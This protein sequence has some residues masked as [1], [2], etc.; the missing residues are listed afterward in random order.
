[1]LQAT[2]CVEVDDDK[3]CRIVND[4]L[5]RWSVKIRCSENQGCGCCVNI[6]QVEAPQ[7]ALNELPTHLV[8][9]K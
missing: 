2:I 1:M 9:L 3:E 6:F 7:E 8:G 5:D 4:W